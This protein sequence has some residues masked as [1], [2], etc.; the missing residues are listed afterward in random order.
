MTAQKTATDSPQAAPPGRKP[1]RKKSPM[2]VVIEQ[3][4]VLRREIA[5]QEEELKDKKQ[6]LRKF[7]EARKIFEAP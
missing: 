2:E 3:T 5:A 4:D 7:E 6:Q 1:W